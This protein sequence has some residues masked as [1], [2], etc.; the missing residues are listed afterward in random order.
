MLGTSSLHQIRSDISTTEL[1]TDL[2]NM[3]IRLAS[4]VENIYEGQ[5]TTHHMLRTILVKVWPEI[6]SRIDTHCPAVGT[7]S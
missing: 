5:K 2:R 6:Y 3:Q 1:L 7:K 4:R